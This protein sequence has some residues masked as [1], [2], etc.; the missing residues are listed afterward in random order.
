LDG[1]TGRT[2]GRV[3]DPGPFAMTLGYLHLYVQS[4]APVEVTLSDWTR[5]ADA[6]ERERYWFELASLA[7]LLGR[8]AEEIQRALDQFQRL[9]KN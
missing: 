6:L 8:P 3:Q 1:E 9:S 4:H 2:V 7:C 5:I